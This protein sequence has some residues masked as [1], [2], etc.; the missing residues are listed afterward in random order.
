M[1]ERDKIGLNSTQ[2]TNLN[3]IRARNF[4]ESLEFKKT[5]QYSQQFESIRRK[6]EREIQSQRLF[7]QEYQILDAGKQPLC[8]NPNLTLV[9]VVEGGSRA[10]EIMG[11]RLATREACNRRYPRSNI[12]ERYY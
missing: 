11:S 12:N 2:C 10:G 9:D 1:I 6:R 7:K 4:H 3:H 8:A 5:I